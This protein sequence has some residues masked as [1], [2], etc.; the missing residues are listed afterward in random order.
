VLISAVFYS[1]NFAPR[2]NRGMWAMI[3]VSVALALWTMV[4]RWFQMRD[5]KREEDEDENRVVISSVSRFS[6]VSSG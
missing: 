4:I 2:F 5:R 6:G 3:G 1:A